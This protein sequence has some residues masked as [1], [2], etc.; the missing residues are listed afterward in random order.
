MCF[1]VTVSNVPL[2]FLVVWLRLS[3]FFCGNGM[4][5]CGVHDLVRTSK[6]LCSSS[7]SFFYG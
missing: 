6:V 4:S 1:R 2:S 3:L 5:K 7:A